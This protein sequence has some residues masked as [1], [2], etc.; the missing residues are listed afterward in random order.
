[1]KSHKP[2]RPAR[3]PVP[4]RCPGWGKTEIDMDALRRFWNK[5]NKTDNCW[6]WIGGKTVAGYGCF[7]LDG[8]NYLTHRLVYAWTY[9][10]F[11]KGLNVCHK[12]DNPSCVRPDHLF[13][14][15]YSENMQDASRKGRLSNLNH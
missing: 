12:C 2:N 10:P 3:A 11:A 9:G 8:R 5:V 15:T 1:M 13:L 4:V 14:G 7:K 6:N